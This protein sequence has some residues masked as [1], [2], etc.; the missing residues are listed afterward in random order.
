MQVS[1]LGSLIIRT[2]IP[3]DQGPALMT[4]VNLIDFRKGPPPNTVRV[5]VRASMYEVFW[6]VRM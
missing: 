2:L 5:G 6:G 4:A 3:L 1:A